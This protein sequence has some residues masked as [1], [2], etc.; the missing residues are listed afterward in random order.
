LCSWTFRTSKCL[1]VHAT[2]S[3]RVQRFIFVLSCTPNDFDCGQAVGSSPGPCV[4]RISMSAPAGWNTLFTCQQS[5]QGYI[6]WTSRS[7]LVPFEAARGGTGLQCHSS[8]AISGAA[9]SCCHAKQPKVPTCTNVFHLGVA[10]PQASWMVWKMAGGMNWELSCMECEVTEAPF[11]DSH[12]R[13]GVAQIC[14]CDSLMGSIAE[15]AR[16]DSVVEHDGPA[17]QQR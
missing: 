1:S 12:S 9:E 7:S 5:V 11:C 3:H 2:S 13:G 6:I 17:N 14:D 4:A 15:W 16:F 10:I 8:V